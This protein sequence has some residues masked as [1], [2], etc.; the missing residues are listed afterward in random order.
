MFEV[1]R[2]GKQI[3]VQTHRGLENA[4]TFNSPLHE[5]NFPASPET[6]SRILLYLKNVNNPYDLQNYLRFKPVNIG[7]WVRTLYY[8]VYRE[9]GLSNRWRYD[10]YVYKPD[11]YYRWEKLKLAYR[12]SGDRSELYTALDSLLR[13]TESQDVV[14]FLFWFL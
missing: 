13:E 4:Q 10:E 14:S 7:D 12:L 5:Y 9:L 6:H 8:S 11:I 3:P 2:E 1:N